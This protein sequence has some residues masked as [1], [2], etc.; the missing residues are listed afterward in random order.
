MELSDIELLIESG[1]Y[2][3]TLSL[4]GILRYRMIYRI[5][6]IILQHFV[7]MELSDIEIAL[8]VMPCRLVFG[9]SCKEA[10]HG[11]RTYASQ[12]HACRDDQ[13]ACSI[14]SRCQVSCQADCA[15]GA[16]DLKHTIGDIDGVCCK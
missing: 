12:V 9:W 10:G 3:S 14:E 7:P 4:H 5:R 1:N 8:C 13:L 11:D 15:A 2:S 16:D 6:E